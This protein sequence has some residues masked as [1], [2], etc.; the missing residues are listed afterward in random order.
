N[1]NIGTLICS[2]INKY[3]KFVWNI[4]NS[5][6]SPGVIDELERPLIERYRVKLNIPEE[7]A[8]KIEKELI[9]KWNLENDTPE[10]LVQSFQITGERFSNEIL[11]KYPLF[12]RDLVSFALKKE[13]PYLSIKTIYNEGKTGALV[14]EIQVNLNNR[15]YSRILKYDNKHK[16]QK[17]YDTFVNNEIIHGKLTSPKCEIV[18]CNSNYAFLLL[19]PASSFAKAEKV[20]SLRKLLV[21]EILFFDTDATRELLID[22]LYTLFDYL[23]NIYKKS[24]HKIQE[25]SFRNTMEQILPARKKFI[26][27]LENSNIPNL[28][29][30]TKKEIFHYDIKQEQEFQLNLKCWDT[31]EKE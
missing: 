7:L 27:T 4:L 3:K 25:Q 18:Y 26:G 8:N 30:I 13:F 29:F 22:P 9:Q 1:K 31:T 11:N 15:F 16:I 21:E 28:L 17:E 10:A 12:K 5:E 2:Q 20:T 14:F 6:I 24:N 23:N 19:E